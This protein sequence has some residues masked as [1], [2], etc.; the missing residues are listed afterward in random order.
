MGKFD[1]PIYD[2]CRKWIQ[3]KSEKNVDWSVIALAGMQDEKELE[4]FLERRE[5]EDDWPRLN[6]YAWRLLVAEV[7]EYESKQQSLIFRGNDGALFDPNQDNGL[8]IPE[9]ERSCWQLYKNGLGWKPDALKNLEDATYGI[10]RR[11]SYDTKATGPIKGLVIGHVQSGKTANMEALMAM[12]ADHGWN[13]FIVLSGTIES[14]RLQTLKRMQKDLNKEGNLIWRGVEHPSKKSQYGER[15]QDLHFEAGSQS[16]YFTVC[17]KNARRL[18]KLIDWIHADRRSHELMRILIIDDEADQASISNTATEY[19]Q[20]IKERKGINKLIVNLVSD[21]HHKETSTN[22][23]AA[24]INYVMYTATPYANFLNEATEDSLY[25]KDFIWTLKTSDEYIGPNQ[26]FG[27]NDPEKPDGLDI[28]R[29]VTDDDLDRIIALY[30]G[31][32]NELP[33]S[34]KDAIAWFLCAVATMRNWNY[35]KPISMLVHT[36]QKQI[37]HD[38]VARAISE[39]INNTG[40]ENIV[41]RCK[42]VYSRETS[43][44]TKQKWLEQFPTYGVPA[45]QISD[46]LT[47]EEILPEIYELLAEQIKHIKLTDEGDFKY[48][49]SLH[50]VID[51]CS[52]NGVHNEDEYIRLAYPD[53]DMDPYPSPAPA[54]IIVG[55]STLSRGLTI[56]GLVSTF[57]LRAS[58]QADTLMQM[59]RWFGYRRH[60]ELMPRIWMTEDTRDKFRFLSELEVDLRDDLKK[61][62]V[63]GVRPIDYGPRILCSPKVSWLKLTS[64]NHMRNAKPAEMDFSGARPQTVIFDDDELIQRKNLGITLEFLEKLGE[65]DKESFDHTALCWKNVPLEQI[66]Q[67]LLINKF[68]FSDRSRVFNEIGAFCEWIQQISK[69]NGLQ[70]WSVVVA[71]T[72]KIRPA[73]EEDQVWWN[74]AGRSLAKVNRSRKPPKNDLDKTIDIGALRALKDLVADIDDL[75]IGPNP[76]ITKQEHVDAIRKKAKMDKVPMLIIYRING[77]SKKRPGTNEHERID[78]NKPYDIIGIQVCVPGD[79]INKSFCKKLT[80]QLPVK[81]KEDEA[82]EIV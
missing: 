61:Y 51:N 57:F 55:G 48:H 43:R 31:T 29:T 16:R 66:M 56:E 50:L 76:K 68:S 19:K 13:M 28:E 62:M 27:F 26:I 73:A 38:A 53:P 45:D 37:F 24:S 32:G 54:F 18:K 69:G 7:Q 33:E 8:K 22:G 25:P 1:L 79:Q 4:I 63:S 80:I 71:G 58:C 49:R 44:I 78:M 64:K 34:M 42:E 5:R 65:P 41:A 14:L 23:C 21:T 77:M 35:K 6:A 3:K 40:T 30:E 60:Y 11:L 9:N 17:L 39:W 74:V 10:L 12:A 72:E 36:S 2:D 52:K 75:Y 70:S 82:E 46:Y 67:Q 59:G 47:F 20:E 81:D 15:A